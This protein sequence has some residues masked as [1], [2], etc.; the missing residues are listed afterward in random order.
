MMDTVTAIN[1]D[2]SHTLAKNSQSADLGAQFRAWVAKQNRWEMMIASKNKMNAFP[3]FFYEAKKGKCCGHC[4]E[5]F[6]DGRLVIL[7][8]LSILYSGPD[9]DWH[10]QKYTLCE[11]CNDGRYN[12]HYMVMR[13]C[14]ACGR[15]IKSHYE[16]FR[17]SLPHCSNKCY[18][19]L[20]NREAR[21]TELLLRSKVT[22]SICSTQ[23]TPNRT[24]S[25]YC[26]SKCRQKAYRQRQATR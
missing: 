12:H 18:W 15:K 21:S 8:R 10:S 6:D 14:F 7:G 2:V 5:S 24:D 1:Q 3:Q 9:R 26:S 17:N 25:R 19:T 16:E 13:D 11:N 20:S 22:C 23:F 4:G